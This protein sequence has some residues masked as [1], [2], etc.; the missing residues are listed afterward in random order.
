VTCHDVLGETWR[1]EASIVSVAYQHPLGPTTVDDWL[2]REHPTDGSR[3]ELI[4][5]Y[6]HVSPP[7]SGQRQRAAFVLARVVEDALLAGGR[8][9]LHVVLGVGV[10]IS[11]PWRTALIPDVVVLNTKPVG[12][13]FQPENLVLAVEIWSPGNT[14]AERETKASA[15]AGADVPYFWVVNQDRVNAMTVTAYRLTDRKYVEEVTAEPGVLTTI[16]AAPVPVTFDP[17]RLH[18]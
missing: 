1:T 14:R 7:P 2:A 10:E 4:L 18:P 5:G 17:A 3:L 8:T 16:N 6:L 11:T 12:T 15:Y 9:D 13:R